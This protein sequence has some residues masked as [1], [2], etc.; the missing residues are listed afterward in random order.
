MSKLHI[1]I[2]CLGMP[3]DGT[4]IVSGTLGGSESAAYY[5]AKGLAALDHKVTMF[6]NCEKPGSFSGVEYIP[7]GPITEVAPMGE[8]FHFYAENTPHDILIIQRHP[9]AF[10]FNYASKVNYWWLHDLA[11]MDN[12]KP[13]QEMLWNIQ[14]VL[15]VSEYHKQQIHDIYGIPKQT[16]TVIENGIDLPAIEQAEAI[17]PKI[18]P[19]DTGLN[20]FYMSRPERGLENLLAKGG[21]M[22]QCPD[23]TLYFCTYNNVAEQM[24][25]YYEALWQRAEQM[26]NVVN[27]GFLNK[28]TLYSV[29]K[30]MDLLVYPTPSAAMPDFREVSCIAMMEAKA[31]GLPVL[32]TGVGALT[33]TLE[34]GGYILAEMSDFPKKIN[35]LT[36]T[37]LE[38]MTALQLSDADNHKWDA[39]VQRLMDDLEEKAGYLTTPARLEKFLVRQSAIFDW[40]D[41]PTLNKGAI[42]EQ[43][44]REYIECYQPF[45][46]KL[47]YAEHYADYYQYEADRGVDYGPENLSGNSRFEEVSKLIEQLPAGATVLDYGCAHGHYTINLALRFP[48]LNFIGVDIEKSNIEKANKWVKDELLPNVTFYWGEFDVEKNVLKFNEEE[49]ED[50]HIHGLITAEVLEHLPE[51]VKT[52]NGLRNYVADNGL[53]IITTPYGP[54]EAIGY[55]EHWPFRAHV[56]DFTRNRIEKMYGHFPAYQLLCVPSGKEKKG[57]PIGSYV[58]WFQEDKDLTVNTS[59][60]FDRNLEVEQYGAR[61]TVSLAMIVKDSVLSLLQCLESVKELVDEVVIGVDEK[62]AEPV[63]DAVRGFCEEH[64]IG[65]NVF[66]IISPI[67]Q[68]FDEARNGV[69]AEAVGD[70]ILWLDSDEKLEGVDNVYKYLHDNCY[71][72][73]AIP[74]HHFSMNP[75]GVIKTDNP[76]KLFR[77]GKGIKFYGCVHEHPELELNGGIGSL[78]ALPDVSIAHYGYDD[79]NIRRDRFSRNFPLLK[80]DRQK[81][82]ERELGHYLWLRDMGQACQFMLEKGEQNSPDFQQCL[83]SGFDTW[84]KILASDNLRMVLESLKFYTL[85]VKCSNPIGRYIE[86]KDR[87][88]ANINGAASAF[89]VEGC[90]L[91]KDDAYNFLARAMKLHLDSLPERYS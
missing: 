90:F 42:G 52:I 48:T 64:H 89:D 63:E 62:S 77:N 82:P 23:H 9:R 38:T 59:S 91:T 41:L 5:V 11:T 71:D 18:K 32:T 20:L 46:N 1:V 75:P 14:G 45:I 10:A 80:K 8:H 87:I 73:Y 85:L 86:I 24:R 79:E 36:D 67:D 27:L 61:Q 53:V 31:T 84:E 26:P 4:T 83:K 15:C 58:Y 47:S 74:Q 35:S 49:P 3:F 25:P 40:M 30:R 34:G 88:G 57:E 13:V 16:I 69:I 39:V 66:P 65:C 2:N 33:E 21:I 37:E 56:T 72:A 70:W 44:Q 7:A 60:L 29:M 68:G 12:V 43:L 51:P 28:E 50:L 81:Y 17:T 19:N 54:W 78:Y 76:T 55:K 22:D 6:T